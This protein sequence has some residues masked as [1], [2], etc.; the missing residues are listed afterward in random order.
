MQ[1]KSE[2]RSRLQI[3]FA[4]QNTYKGVVARVGAEGVEIGQD[5]EVENE[6]IVFINCFLQPVEAFFHFSEAQINMD[7]TRRR[8]IY[9]LSE[10]FQFV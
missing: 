9:L 7:E 6:A 2:A 8:R 10:F 3:Y 5:V 4:L 1:S